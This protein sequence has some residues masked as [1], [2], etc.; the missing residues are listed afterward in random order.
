VASALAVQRAP[1]WSGS[2]LELAALVASSGWVVANDS[3]IAHLAAL[4]GRPLTLLWKEGADSRW[5]PAGTGG[6]IKRWLWN[7]ATNSL[8]LARSIAAELSVRQALRGRL[9]GQ[10][11]HRR[12]L[13]QVELE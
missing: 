8:A 9:G 1:V 11:R 13:A 2:A 6:A 12:A 10:G 4:L 7:E 5:L 3:G